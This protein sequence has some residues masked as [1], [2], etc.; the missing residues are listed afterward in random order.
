MKCEKCNNREAIINIIK[1]SKGEKEA[2]WLCDYCAKELMQ[3]PISKDEINDG[4]FQ[5]VLNS[6][7][8]ALNTSK[9]NSDKLD[10]LKCDG[11]GLTYKELKTTG[12]LGC[13]ECFKAF[14]G[15]LRPI[16][17]RIQGDLEHIG[18][19]PKRAG[20]DIL[21]NKTLKKLKD[22]L[23]IAIIEEEYE[24]AAVLR[25]KIKAFEKGDG[26]E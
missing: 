25:D 18:K 2:I 8:Q 16:I 26:D 10:T 15:Q 13:E 3:L 11:C 24:K 12:R 6:F 17:K 7:L 20:R 1:V 22:E 23:Q 9:N 5:G 14:E 21:K 4:Y 19:I